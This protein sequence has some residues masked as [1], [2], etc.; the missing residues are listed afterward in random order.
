[1]FLCYFLCAPASCMGK[2][3]SLVLTRTPQSTHLGGSELS[4]APVHVDLVLPHEGKFPGAVHEA[5]AEQTP[6][7]QVQGLLDACGREPQQDVTQDTEGAC[8]HPVGDQV[9]T[10]WVLWAP[11]CCTDEGLYL[12]HGTS[13]S[14]AGCLQPRPSSSDRSGQ[15][16]AGPEAPGRRAHKVPAAERTPNHEG[17]GSS[18]GLPWLV[19]GAQHIPWLNSPPWAA[20]K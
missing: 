19:M 3:W 10:R 2:L 5:R 9:S 7:P 11:Q 20:G 4:A 18:R 12:P 1:M 8:P 16:G 13:P 6:L 15:H 17:T 14:R